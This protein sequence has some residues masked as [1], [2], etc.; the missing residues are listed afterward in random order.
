MSDE[1]NDGNQM[2][3]VVLDANPNQLLFA[4]QQGAFSQWMNAVL[5]FVNSH[6]MLH[7]SNK[8]AV[9]AAHATGCSFLYPDSDVDP[10]QLSRQ[11]VLSTFLFLNE[12]PLIKCCR[13]A[14]MKSSTWWK[15]LSS[16]NYIEY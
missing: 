11:Q 16:K 9:L 4:R 5:T 6:L 8:V 13:M 1:N 12:S 14:S 7:P 10:N 3:V 15:L 2:L